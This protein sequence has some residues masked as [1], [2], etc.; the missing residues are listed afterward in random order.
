MSCKECGGRG[1]KQLGR[2]RVRCYVCDG[3][4]EEKEG[5]E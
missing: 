5:G 3:T 1:Y 2:V 4:G